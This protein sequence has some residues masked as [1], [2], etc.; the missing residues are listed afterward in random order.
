MPSGVYDRGGPQ[1]QAARAIGERRAH[2]R[3]WQSKA[4]FHVKQA[5]KY[6]RA[7]DRKLTALDALVHRCTGCGGWLLAD[8][9]CTTCGVAGLT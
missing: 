1:T 6:A 4:M 5:R 7:R 2:A 9:E 3:G 8:A